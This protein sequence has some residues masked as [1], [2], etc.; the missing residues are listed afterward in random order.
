M[1]KL[2]NFMCLKGVCAKNLICLDTTMLGGIKSPH[3]LKLNG[4]TK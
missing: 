2:L 4:E 1:S 3:N